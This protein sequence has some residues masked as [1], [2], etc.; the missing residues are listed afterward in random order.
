M[1]E[2]RTQKVK[3]ALNLARKAKTCRE[4]MDAA[5]IPAEEFKFAA[6][7]LVDLVQ[8]GLV[9]ECGTRA[10]S[11]SGREVKTYRKSTPKAAPAKAARRSAPKKNWKARVRELVGKAA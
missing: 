1:T 5:G 3:N 8:R 9:V 2:G 7:I 4:L 11:I 10:C 6:S